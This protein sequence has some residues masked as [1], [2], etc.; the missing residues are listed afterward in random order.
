MAEKKIEMILAECQRT[1][2]KNRAVGT[3]IGYFTVIIEQEKFKDLSVLLRRRLET[4]SLY[5]KD[6][7]GKWEMTGG[8]AEI[9][10]FENVVSEQS[11][12][13]KYQ[14]SIF[15]T[16]EQELREE[17]GLVLL[18]LPYPLMMV[19]A[20]LLRTY[21]D[22]K[23]E[24]ERTTIDLA[25]SIPIPW[26]PQYVIAGDEFEE[27]LKKGELRFVTRD[28]LKEIEIISPRTR[29][30]IEQA[31]KAFEERYPIE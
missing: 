20:N 7:S 4:D 19:P 11:L 10:H 16:L 28:E 15:Q 5:G 6:L 8:G 18:N 2:A 29:F 24:E 27:K 9:Q 21:N 3:G 26:D 31:I 12:V 17:A 23:T 1:L 13:G 22:A 14:G 30:L 25:F